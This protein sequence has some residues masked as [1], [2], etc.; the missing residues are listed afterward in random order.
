MVDFIRFPPGPNGEKVGLDDYLRDHTVEELYAL[1]EPIENLFAEGRASSWKEKDL[2]A[3]LSGKVPRIK[4]DLCV[5]DDGVCLF[6][7]GRVNSL[8]G[9]STEGKTWV[10]L[11]ACKQ[12]LEKGAHVIYVDYED[13]EFGITER[14]RDMGVKPAVILEFFHYINPDQPYSDDARNHLKDMVFE[15]EPT[16]VVIDS[17]G[18]SMA[19]DDVRTNVDEDVSSWNRRFP[20]R[21]ARLDPGVV[22]L[23]HVT[24][25]PTTRRGSASGSHRKKDAID[26]A[27]Y[28]VIGKKEFGRGQWGEAQLIT[29]KDRLGTHVRNKPAGTFML[30]ARQPAYD[31]SLDAPTFEGQAGEFVP[32]YLMEKISRHLEVYPGA[33]KNDLRSLGKHAYIDEAI[34]KLVPVYVRVESRGQSHRHFNV[35]PYREGDPLVPGEEF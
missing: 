8:F 24:K 30:D 34:M 25:D 26:G 21:V 22:T 17:A 33:S 1:A 27:A 29:R 11:Y 12:E 16:L 3:A 4:P 23:D 2:R 32:T 18:E 28:E 9:E 35:K 19:L 7:S 5:R 10:A 13:D 14:L 6:Y 31:V 15:Y 20:K